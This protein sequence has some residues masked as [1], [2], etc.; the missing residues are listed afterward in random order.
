MLSTSS[1]GRNPVG[2]LLKPKLPESAKGFAPVRVVLV[3]QRWSTD[4][5]HGESGW[6]VACVADWA[7]DISIFVPYAAHANRRAAHRAL[8]LTRKP[9][10]VNASFR[11]SNG[12]DWSRGRGLC[13][14]NK[15]GGSNYD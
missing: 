1:S 12:Q 13:F 8:E 2:R 11:P 7:V 9:R 3:E 15:V 10:M 6:E 5:R 4:E 14:T